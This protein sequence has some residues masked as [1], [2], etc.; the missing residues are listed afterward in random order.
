MNTKRKVR[1]VL[2]HDYEFPIGKKTLVPGIE[3]S[4][5]GKRGRYRFQYARKT[6]TGLDELTFVGGPL[7]GQGEHYVSAYPERVTRIHRVNKTLTNIQ[8]EKTHGY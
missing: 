5:R 6:S 2:D 1:Q 7:H 8:K 4:L 3:V